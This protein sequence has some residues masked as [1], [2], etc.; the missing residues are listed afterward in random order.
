MKKVEPKVESDIEKGASMYSNPCNI[1]N[2][3]PNL[4]VIVNLVFDLL[5]FFFNISW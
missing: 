4:M 5:K 3:V 1:E 2:N